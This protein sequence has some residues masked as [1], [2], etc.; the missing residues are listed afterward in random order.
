MR[1]TRQRVIA[2][3]TLWIST[4]LGQADERPNLLLFLADDMTY[5]DVG[6]FGNPDVRTPNIDRLAKQ[7]LR[8]T[9]CYNSAPTCS[10]LRQSLFTGLYPVRNGAHPNHSR[11]HEGVKSL[12]HHL[13]P[14]G[15]R[16]GLVG[17]R[18]EA[19]ASAFPFEQLGG[20]HG[21]GG[22]TPAGADLP[23]DRAKAFMA[24][25]GG[26]PWCLVVASNQPHTPWNRGDASVYPP[27]KLTV[28]PYLVDTKR[29]REGLS[30]YYAEISYMDQQVG[31]VVDILREMKQAENT[32]ILWLSEQGSQLP[33][34]K[35][36]CYDMGIHAAA[37]VRW[38]GRIKPGSESTALI[39]YVDVVPTFLELAG[40]SPGASSFDGQSFLPVLLGKKQVH[41]SFVYAV[42][43]T[44]GIYHGSEAYGIRALTDG[45]WLYIHNLH[46]GARFQNMVTYRDPIY[47]SW[48]TVDSDFAR[49]RVARYAKRPAVELFDLRADPW[50]LRNLADD[51]RLAKRSKE[52]SRRLAKWMKQ[53]GDEGDATERL[54]KSRQPRER[55][56]S[57][58][59]IYYKPK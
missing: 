13:R 49:S 32:V 59:G 27:E 43:T 20:S 14:L 5:T 31:E 39:S 55:P 33:F 25:D 36:T 15:Y 37:V 8:L 58:K 47:A 22:R 38:P 28:P 1:G 52:F 29:L 50:C 9:R 46:P 34:G 24:R 53:Q 10:P 41:H 12:P 42:N 48:K 30:K 3:I 17:K 57:K 23:L 2:A 18:H 16:V 11:V 19:P 44:R 26:Q 56:W 45:D 7:G 54:A 4:A 35:W 21:D 6:C 40:G 51:S